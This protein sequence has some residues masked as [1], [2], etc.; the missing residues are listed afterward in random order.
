MKETIKK[1]IELLSIWGN[2]YRNCDIELS[3]GDRVSISKERGLV[4]YETLCK[5]FTEGYAYDVQCINDK[6]DRMLDKVLDKVKRAI[7]CDI[8]AY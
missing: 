4:F 3:N 2:Q 8:M 6:P 5:D 1:I 7:S